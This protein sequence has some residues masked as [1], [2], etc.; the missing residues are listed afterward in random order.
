MI[1]SDELPEVAQLGKAPHGIGG[2]RKVQPATLAPSPGQP[3]EQD[4]QAGAV[5]MRHIREVNVDIPGVGEEP[6]GLADQAGNPS[7]VQVARDT[8]ASPLDPVQHRPAHP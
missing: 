4:R 5:G 3:F 8:E 2:I 7:E 1:R 6:I